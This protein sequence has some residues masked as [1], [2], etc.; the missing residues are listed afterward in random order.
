ME[1]RIRHVVEQIGEI[2]ALDWVARPLKKTFD[3]AVKPGTAK[4]LFAGTWLGHP[5]HPV[6]TDIPIGAWSSSVLLDYLGGKR[7]RP[8]ADA[9]LGIGIVSA[10]P[11]AWS[12]LTDWTDTWGKAQR[13]GVAHALGNA[14]AIGLFTLSF[15]ARRRGHRFRG[16]MLS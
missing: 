1:P 6:L 16:V 2:D 15:R 14:A 5:L 11:T 7:A 9:L 12:G 10:L 3:R 8:A 13:V 4:D